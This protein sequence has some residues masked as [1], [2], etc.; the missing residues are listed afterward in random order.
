MCRDGFGL[1]AIEQHRIRRER[2]ER[3]QGITY[4]FTTA[5]PLRSWRLAAAVQSLLAHA[6]IQYDDIRHAGI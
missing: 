2:F 4:G 1:A 6:A 5:Q 3:T